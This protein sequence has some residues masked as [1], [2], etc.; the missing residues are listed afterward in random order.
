MDASSASLLRIQNMIKL[1]KQLKLPVAFKVS[2]CACSTSFST[3]A[4]AS[5]Q[6]LSC[7]RCA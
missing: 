2:P 5:T 6:L 7:L 1:C 3:P 4:A